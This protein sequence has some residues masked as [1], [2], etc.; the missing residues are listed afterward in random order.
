M[1]TVVSECNGSIFEEVQFIHLFLSA[2]CR[3][4]PKPKA[5]VPERLLPALSDPAGSCVTALM[6]GV[7][8]VKGYVSLQSIDVWSRKV[9]TRKAIITLCYRARR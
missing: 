6:P 5:V 2:S 4:S 8:T 9:Q 3:H 7:A 1:P